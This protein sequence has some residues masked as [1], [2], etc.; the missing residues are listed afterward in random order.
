MK[1]VAIPEVL[2]EYK[3]VGA[4]L[5]VLP[6]CSQFIPMD[7][8]NFPKY[9]S[10]IYHPSL[11]PRH[12]GASAI[13]CFQ[14]GTTFLH[15]TRF[16]SIRFRSTSLNV[17][18]ND[19]VFA[20]AGAEQSNVPPSQPA[21]PPPPAPLIINP[22]NPGSSVDPHLLELLVGDDSESGYHPPEFALLLYKTL[23][24]SNMRVIFEVDPNVRSA[25]VKI[26][27]YKKRRTKI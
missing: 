4:E 19:F 12:R 27:V 16:Y 18:E 10:I 14:L 26:P 21:P 23:K 8:I 15:Y 6:F 20:L 11:L 9:Q 7:V 3:S 17:T 24:E 1:K 25:I 2:E 13:N 5:N 22:R